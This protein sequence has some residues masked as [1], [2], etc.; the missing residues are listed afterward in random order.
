MA[1]LADTARSRGRLTGPTWLRVGVI[2]AVLLLCFV[3]ARSCQQS[4]V[5]I[6]K[7]QAIATAERQVDFEPRRVQIRFLRQGVASEPFWIVSLSVPGA[8]EDSFRELTFVRIDANTGK[9]T[10]VQDRTR[11]D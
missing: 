9:V 11:P 10:D 6:T 1:A 3:V 4:Q 7:D 5:R 8:R 2:A